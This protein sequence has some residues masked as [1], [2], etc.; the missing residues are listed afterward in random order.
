LVDPP[1]SGLY[2]KV[3]KGVMYASTEAEGT[4][5]RHQVDTI[6]EGIGINRITRN[7]AL[8]QLD[9]GFQVA[10]REAVEMAYYL[11]RQE[12][13][14]LGSSSGVN[15]VG[16]VKLARQLGPGHTI[17]TV[18]CDGGARYMSKLYNEAFLEK[19]GILPEATGLEFIK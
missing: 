2:N 1:G 9:G 15:C 16:A 12:G 18:L 4:R 14:F 8:A 5:R 7:F 19:R 6:T 13:L 3:V 10:D 17:V 11:M